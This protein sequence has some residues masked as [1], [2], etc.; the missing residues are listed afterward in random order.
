MKKYKY[1][2]TLIL[3]ITLHPV[4]AQDVN[5]KV[6][7]KPVP[8]VVQPPPEI[9][10]DPGLSEQ[11]VFEGD[12]LIFWVH[13]LG[14][15][16]Y[17]WDAAAAP[18]ANTYKVT[19]LLNGIDY[20]TYSLTN[21]G[22]VLQTTIDGQAEIYGQLNGIEDPA[23]T[24]FIIA[25]S[26]GGI[27]SRAAYKRY[28]DLDVVDERSFGGIVTF[29]SPH[30]G[31]QIINNV[32]DIIAYANQSCIDLTIGPA[33]EA[34]NGSWILGFAPDQIMENAINSLCGFMSHTV[35]PIVMQDYLEPITE[36]Y[37]VGASVITELNEFD[38]DPTIPIAKVA[39]Y[40]IEEAPVVWRTV[41]SLTNDVNAGGSFSAG[42]DEE[43]ME[44]ANSNFNSYY[45]K[46]LAYSNLYDLTSVN[47]TEIVGAEAW[48]PGWA[49]FVCNPENLNYEYNEYGSLINGDVQWF[50]YSLSETEENRDAYYTGYRWWA[51]V[52]ESYL[53]LIGAVEYV[54]SSCHCDCLEKYGSDPTPYEALHTI[55]CGGNCDYFEDNPPPNTN[56]IHCDYAVV[57]E[58]NIKPN[59]GVVL[60]ESAQNYPGA[61]NGE[62]NAMIGSNHMQMRNDSN[63][64]T[65]LN[66]LI[67]GNQGLFFV[68]EER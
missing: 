31:A 63:T 55:D 27:V 64:G 5:V 51:N 2:L 10:N 9:I 45:L 26:Q 54:V 60:V 56:V 44:I 22:Q 47:C 40:G 25:H 35:L 32:D 53:S 19:S 65:Q 58:K 3:I 36:D 42:Y 49:S 43:Y 66:S 30:Q 38:E 39:F 41:Y 11:S 48:I 37:Q 17:S 61:N 46:Y 28:A 14:G 67:E 24:N 4:F 23:H 21:A 57:Y 6:E 33:T 20:S 8:V 52:E 15:T 12:R 13:G 16:A 18:T 62:G 7:K 59:D 34:W 1:I 68:T 50:P 29:G